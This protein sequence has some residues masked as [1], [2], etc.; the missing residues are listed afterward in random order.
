MESNKR[1][2]VEITLRPN[3]VYTPFQ[4]SWANI[5]YWVLALAS[6]WILYDLY[7]APP[8]GIRFRHIP[9]WSV[10]VALAI[11]LLTVLLGLQYLAALRLFRKYPLFAKPRRLTF[12]PE[13]ILIESEDA[14]AECRW[15]VFSRIGES[16]GLFFF[17]QTER[18][19]TYVPKRCLKSDREIQLM[20]E[21]IRENFK[22]R[23]QLWR[24]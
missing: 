2:S 24:R 11:V 3:D 7:F 12:S 6:A 19:A 17:Q 13:G 8:D 22:G 15:T 1:L 4:W 16:S 5:F 10:E 20:R 23:Y 18:T 14:R 21:L 9:S